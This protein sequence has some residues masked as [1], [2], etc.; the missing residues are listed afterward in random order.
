MFEPSLKNLFIKKIYPYTQRNENR[1][2]NN[3]NIKK[4]NKNN[5][6]KKRK[7]KKNIRN[8]TNSPIKISPFL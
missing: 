6:N 4:N 8:K 1:I 7:E 3:S 2:N 5:S